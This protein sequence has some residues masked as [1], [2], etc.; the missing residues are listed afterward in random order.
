MKK[1]FALLAG[2]G[3]VTLANASTVPTNTADMSY[4]VA[5][6]V[7]TAII[8]LANQLNWQVGDFHNI[9][10]KMAFGGGT[11]T[12]TVTQDVPAEGAFWYVNEMSLFGQAQKTEALM[13][14]SDGKV[15]KL[16]VNGKEQAPESDDSN[17]EIIEQFKE[18]QKKAWSTFAPTEI[19]TCQPAARL[20]VFAGITAGQRVLDVGR[21]TGVVSLAAARLGARVTGL[22]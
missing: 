13:R 19:Y 16:I 8:Q 1:I 4:Q 21:G 5:K 20:A 11:G 22:D 7:N 17:I 15:L 2:A 9:D 14:R 12:K 10:I 3:L 6:S 18:N